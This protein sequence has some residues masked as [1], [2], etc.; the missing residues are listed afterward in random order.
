MV[1]RWWYQPGEVM[2]APYPD[3]AAS[4]ECVQGTHASAAFRFGM[5]RSSAA[6]LAAGGSGSRSAG[7]CHAP[8]TTATGPPVSFSAARTACRMCASRRRSRSGSSGAPSRSSPIA[9]ARASNGDPPSTRASIRSSHQRSGSSYPAAAASFP[10]GSELNSLSSE[11]PLRDSPCSS[12]SSPRA[13]TIPAGRSQN[14][15]GTP[16]ARAQVSACHSGEKTA[17][18]QNA[19]IRGSSG[20]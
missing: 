9:S 8:H 16:R 3:A 7:A 1:N 17:N 14:R 12:S 2:P 15:T 20:A 4:R 13:S 19:E 18:G 10:M 11:R 5:P 6:S